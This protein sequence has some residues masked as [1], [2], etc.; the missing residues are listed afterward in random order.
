[1][2]LLT[3]RKDSATR[4]GFFRVFSFVAP[5][6]VSHRVASDASPSARLV[7]GSSSASTDR[8]PLRAALRVARRADDDVVFTRRVLV[9]M[10]AKRA[11]FY[12]FVLSASRQKRERKRIEENVVRS[13]N[14]EKKGVPSTHRAFC[15]VYFCLSVLRSN[16]A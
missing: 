6:V 13:R 14:D 9:A 2:R 16:Y 10:T 15:C 5:P 1:L 4:T 8:P 12:S 11:L 7:D 3:A